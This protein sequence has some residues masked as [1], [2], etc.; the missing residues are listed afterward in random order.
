MNGAVELLSYGWQRHQSGDL[1]GAEAAY[2]QI[3][4]ADPDHADALRLLGVLCH[5]RGQSDESLSYLRRV[6]ELH[7][8][9]GTAHNNLGVVLAARRELAA[10]AGC[11]ERALQCNPQSTEAACNLANVLRE[12]G[13]LDDSLAVLH[14]ARAWA[15]DAAELHAKI[16]LTEAA[17]GQ[18]DAAVAAYEQALRLEPRHLESL[19][20]LGI[21]LTSAGRLDEAVTKLKRAVTLAAGHAPAHLALGLAL[22]QQRQLRD[23]ANALHRAVQLDRKLTAAFLQLGIVHFELGEMPQ[24]AA[25]LQHALELKPDS[26]ITLNNLGCALRALRQFDR[27]AERLE[28]AVRLQPDYAEAWKNL[29]LVRADQG[30]LDAALGSIEEARRLSPQRCDILVSLGNTLRD[31]GRLDDATASYQAALA[32]DPDLEDARNYL[33]NCLRDLGRF[34]EAIEQYDRS[35]ELRPESVFAHLNRAM[36]WLRRGDF[37][38]GWSEYEWRWKVAGV[39]KPVFTQPEWDGSPI[40]GRTILLYTEQGLGDTIQ[41]IRYAR[42]LRDEGARVL[43]QCDASMLPLLRQVDGIDQVVASGQALPP[44]HV[45]APLLS[46]PRLAATRV[47]SIP[48]DLP[49]IRP[50]E[51]LAT[52]WE[53]ALAGIRG[54][55]VGIVWQGNPSYALE[56]FRSV[57]LR[58]FRPLAEIEGA[59]LIS[60][61]KGP[62]CE[63]IEGFRATHQ[64]I[65]LGG[66]LDAGGAFVDTAAVLPHL[67]LVVS[68]DTAIA[69]LAGAMNVP[70][71]LLTSALSDWRWLHDRSDS[72]WYPS[73]RIWRQQQLGDWAELVSRVSSELQR[74]ATDS[75]RR[76]P[77]PGSSPTKPFAHRGDRVFAASTS[78]V[79]FPHFTIKPRREISVI[80]P[81]RGH[82]ELIPDYEVC[83]GGAQVIVIDNA[84]DPD[85]SAAVAG[86]VERLGGQLIRNEV[87][88]GFAA[89][90]NQ[91]LAVASGEIV[92]FLNSDVKGRTDFLEGVS[93]GVPANA[94]V[95]PAHCQQVVYGMWLPYLE[96]WCIAGHRAVWHRLDGWDA[97]AFPGP[98]WED[99]DV[100][101]RATQM[102]IQLLCAKWPIQHKGGRTTQGCQR[103]GESFERNRTTFAARVRAA[104]KQELDAMSRDHEVQPVD[105]AGSDTAGSDVSRTLRVDSVSIAVAPGELIDKITILEIKAARITQPEK[106]ANVKV[107]LDL[108]EHARRRVWHSTPELDALEAQLKE[109]N[110]RLWDI[111]DDLRECE[112]RRDFGPQFVE[113][114]R[115]V[116]HQND[117]RADLKRR[118]NTALGA[119]IIEEKSYTNYL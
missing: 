87:N 16:G 15:P 77:P 12:L 63:Q 43:V 76:T 35:I 114:A 11:F 13:R 39:T 68:V 42:L 55:R 32:I 3:L 60:L 46:L 116:Y 117:H 52:R 53:S 92:L 24:A 106:L 7:P 34:Q 74:R 4:L 37:E 109:T 51:R 9:L 26:P 69:H 59:Q 93:R 41:F 70:V 101:F 40:A 10:A 119:R 108:L 6:I 88:R 113:L 86:M 84:S 2:R 82:A 107:E 96:G 115:S 30:D 33:A 29:G 28:H 67:D 66:D 83:V 118:I 22:L 95:G 58:C 98:Y 8:E 104:F 47:E 56:R 99:S 65:D 48:A 49:Y 54:F 97:A 19:T 89:A 73:M 38:R 21:A 78:G 102:G 27:A 20:N 91:G 17:R 72:P 79:E 64:L 61:Q 23:A 103:W 111:E 25:A 85:V 31:A 5:Q 81:W 1:R 80:T 110:Q 90:N 100:C 14:A 44:F 105:A 50:D 45:H 62:G 36:T 112:R 57:G 75:P 71:W 94:L 18:P